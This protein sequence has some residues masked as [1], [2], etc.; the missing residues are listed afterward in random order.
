[1]HTIPTDKQFTGQRLD[2]TGLYYYNAR[3]YDPAIGR[4]IS[5]DTVVQDLNNPQCLNR[6]SYC[7]NNPLKYTDPTGHLFGWL[8]KAVKWVA[9]KVVQ[10]ATVVK[11]AVVKA[12]T[13]VKEK[14]VQAATWVKDK[15]VEAA[16]FV[17]EKVAPVV[18]D[19]VGH[20]WTAP[21]TILG[22]AAGALSG[23]TP[24]IGPRGTIIFENVSPSSPTGKLMGRYNSLTLGYVVLTKDPQIST[25]TLEHEL[26]HVTQY[27]ILGLSF[28]PIYG[29][30]T[31]AFGGHDNNPMEN[32]LLPNWP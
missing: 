15:V 12:A 6:Y 14:V 19:V 17:K 13:V 11:K 32:E 28:L 29:A 1:M 27:A 5:A 7:I 16:T 2:T 20:V 23:G 31:V 8:K 30:L 26:G 18:F 9:K 10:V 24:R 4:F 3:Y 22:L 25:G 21:N